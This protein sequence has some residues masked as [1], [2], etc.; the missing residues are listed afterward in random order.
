MHI[1]EEDFP[2]DIHPDLLPDEAAQVVFFDI[3]TTG[4]SG[5]SAF[6]Y[7]IG[8]IYYKE[9]KWRLR[10]WFLDDFSSEKEL[11]LSFFDF[12]S[13]YTWL[14]HFNGSTF[15][16]PFI[17]KRLSRYKLAKSFSF[18]ESLDL[19]KEL[20]PY[21]ALLGLSGLKQKNLEEFLGIHRTDKFSGGELIEV[22][23]E[24]MDTKK[25]A[26]L[27][28]LLLHNADDLRGMISILPLH[29]LVLLFKGAFEV[30]TH[31][32]TT[33]LLCFRL[34]CS[35]PLPTHLELDFGC[36]R[37]EINNQ[38]ICFAVPLITEELKYFYPNPKDYYYLPAEDQAIHKSIAAYVDKSCRIA[39]NQSNCYTRHKSTYLPL[40]DKEF[41]STVFRRNHKE[42]EYFFELNEDFLQ[43]KELQRTYLL[44]L[45]ASFR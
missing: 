40:K 6:L 28:V 11:L 3:E 5:Q 41:A 8:C 32:Q 42:K 38:N 18:F 29:G 27:S 12:I 4:F 26:L 24:Y 16:I 34:A 20:K 44:Q 21:K 13:A 9:N 1:V 43:N 22:Y 39:A 19:Y 17:E 31:E 30:T 7:L 36:G 33:S 10:Q 45:L 37:L 35:L 15:D 23:Y 2:M 25:D 14:I